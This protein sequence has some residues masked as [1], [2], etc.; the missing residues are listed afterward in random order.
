MKPDHIYV[1]EQAVEPF[2]FDAR[3]SEVFADMIRRSV[4]GYGLTLQMLSVLAAEYVQQGS[5]VYDLGCSLGASTLAVRHGI[6]AEDCNI[7]AVD[8]SEAMLDSCQT[9][10]DADAAA[11]PVLLRCADIQ[12]VEIQDASMVVLNFTLQFIPVEERTALLQRIAQGLRP[13]G[14]LVLSEKV[15][16]DDATSQQQQIALHEGFKR[17]QGYSDIEIS[18]KRQALEQVLMPETVENHHARLR[19]AGFQHSHTWFQCFNFVSILA[20]R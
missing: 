7:I 17:M 19:D 8:H 1:H 11:T 12:D 15:R 20:S 14:V 6:Q 13:N 4:P 2:C 18:R 5:T 3:V 9:H 10:V 16:F